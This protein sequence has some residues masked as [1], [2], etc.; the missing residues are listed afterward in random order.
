M[1]KSMLDFANKINL[2]QKIVFSKTLKA[3]NWNNTQPIREN[4]VEEIL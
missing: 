1:T 4:A 2:L 3:V